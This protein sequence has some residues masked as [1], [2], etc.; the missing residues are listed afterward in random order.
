M[1]QYRYFFADLLTNQ[2]AAELEVTGVNFT[3][4]INSAGTFSGNILLTGLS[5][6]SNASTATTPGRYAIYVD[7][8]GIIV[9][10]GII[11]HR[12]YNSTSQHLSVTAQEMES[13]FGRR[14][15]TTTTSYYNQDQL[16]VV[17]GLISAAQAATNGNIGVQ[18]GVDPNTGQPPLSGVTI[19][20]TY[21]GYE[22]KTVLSAIQ[23]LA[24]SGT[25]APGSGGF[26]FSITCGYDSLGNIAKTLNLGYPRLGTAYNAAIPTIP[27]FE[28]PSGNIIEYTYPEDGSIVA[29]TIYATGAG[30]NEGKLIY[31]ASNTTLLTQGWPLLEDTVSYNDIYDAS[32]IQ[33]LANGHVAAVSYPPTTVSLIV[34][35]SQDPVLGSYEIGD[36]ARLR[37]QDDRFPNG[38]DAVYRISALNVTPGEAGPERAT[39]TLTLPTTS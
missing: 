32:V 25:G 4:A 5:A 31:S 10:G 9:W 12:E 21:Y 6:A 28:F 22:Q 36:D 23:D 2:I 1:T 27:T 7:R 37:I 14:R 19:A 34:N 30:S 33:N 26:D 20:R 16:T 15:I 18:I 13:Y 24:K 17:A 35:P 38:L 11:W 8:N 3:Q 39:L 29:N